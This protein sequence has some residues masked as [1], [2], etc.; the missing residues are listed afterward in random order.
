MSNSGWWAYA[1]IAVVAFFFLIISPFLL[2]L[3]L[4]SAPPGLSASN[5]VL[6][7]LPAADEATLGRN[8]PAAFLLGTMLVESGG[9]VLATD[10]DCSNEQAAGWHSCGELYGSGVHTVSE[11]AGLMQVNS[12]GWPPPTVPTWNRY[13]LYPDPVDPRRNIRAGASL[14][15]DAFAVSS[16]LAC[17]AQTYHRGNCDGGG[18][19]GYA[20]QVEAAYAHYQGQTILNAWAGKELGGGEHLTNGPFL[21]LYAVGSGPYGAAGDFGPAGKERQVIPPAQVYA[22]VPGQVECSTTAKGQK[23]L[24]V[25]WPL[26]LVT[27]GNGDLAPSLLFYPGMGVWMGRVNLTTP[28]SSFSRAPEGAVGVV[29]DWFH[30]APGGKEATARA[31]TTVA[32]RLVGP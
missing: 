4:V 2:V 28:P 19:D 6:L 23:C 31:D 16:S 22:E 5:R 29:A 7:W 14:L 17:V 1:L 24:Q 15:E 32:V 13:G 20:A 30:Q 27:V 21:T 18:G 9:W 10:H 12:G 25:E 26:R 11:D 8:F 3:R